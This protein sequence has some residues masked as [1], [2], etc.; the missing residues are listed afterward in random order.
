MA[1]TDNNAVTADPVSQ[2]KREGTRHHFSRN[3]IKII[4]F[5]D[6][7]SFFG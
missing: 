5:H 7:L 1:L 6:P 3:S 2:A 4:I